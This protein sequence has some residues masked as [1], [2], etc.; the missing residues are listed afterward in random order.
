[1][2]LENNKRPLEVSDD[3]VL[4]GKKLKHE[5]ISV[6]S[7]PEG[8]QESDVGITELISSA[9]FGIVGLLKQRYTDFLVNEV[10]PTGKTIHLL[11]EGIPDKRERRRER[12]KADREGDAEDEQE[13]SVEPAVPEVASAN[14]IPQVSEEQ[15]TKL[16][17]LFGEKDFENIQ[18]LFSTGTFFETSNRFDDKMERTNIHKLI[19][20]AYQGR[21]ET[22]TTDMNA[23]KIALTT[24]GQKKG[25]KGSRR[26]GGDNTKL[27]HT[28]G[29]KKDYL[30]FDMYKENKETMEVAALLGKLFKIPSKWIKYAGTK[31][32]RAVTVQRLSVEKLGVE[33]VNGLNKMLKGIRLGGFAYADSA[34][35]LGDLQG[36]AFVI[37]IK[38]VQCVKEGQSIEVAVKSSLES[39]KAK[40][41]INYFGMQRFGTFSI[42]TH[43]VGTQLLKANWKQ[44]VNMLLS[45][46]AIVVPD[47]IEA[48]RIWA[49]TKNPQ[50]AAEKMPKR[51]SAEY[52]ILRRL[53]KE[54]KGEDGDWN[55]NGYFNAIMAIP[56]N[57][58]IMYG[59]A[60]QSY[61]WNI[62]ASK[63]IRLFGLKVVAGDLVLDEE[64]PKLS[65]KVGENDEEFQEDIRKDMFI[66]ARYLS[67]ADV[68]SGKYTIYDVVLPTPGFDIKYPETPEMMQVYKDVMA[69]DGLD[70]ENMTSRIREFS[71]A[72]S[73]RKV[74]GR[75]LNLEYFV[76]KYNDPNEPLVRTD[77]EILRLK[78][79]AE[80]EGKTGEISQILDGVPD[81]ASTAVIIKMQLG[82]SAYATM[83]L[84]EVL[85]Q[86]TSRR[87][88]QMSLRK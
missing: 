14:Q 47:S 1:M 49:E 64:A 84:R 19:R 16:V 12:R 85:R 20:E 38:D 56:R 10:D 27:V 34:L 70:P 88:D 51:C 42:S 23:F 66:R 67:Q 2:T 65:P 76:R 71:L 86:D 68:D 87:G 52:S 62:A 72:G 45:E 54:R 44:A 31:D 69:A 7:K 83:A 55:G 22:L 41:F 24:K 60:Y 17:A 35:S 18:E 37:T 57:L 48:R 13:E 33:R 4:D 82:V 59:H 46:Q 25:E 5:S 32:R 79:E 8:I 6:D 15:K 30:H 40:G 28:L 80:L 43:E 75:A 36:N 63:R 81:G 78:Q 29:P 74:M 21:L 9:E 58:R 39:L 77:L 61:V 53:E 3:I 73:Y 11:D 50:R 26:T